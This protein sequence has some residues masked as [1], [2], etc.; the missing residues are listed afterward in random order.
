MTHLV[1]DIIEMSNSS[2]GTRVIQKVIE[3]VES[4]SLIE[5]ILKKFKEN[6]VGLVLDSNGNHVI[7]KCLSYFVPEQVDFM[8]MEI[9]AS[10]E[11][12]AT[13]KH[14][15]CVLQRCIDYCN[16]DQIKFVIGGILNHT[17]VLINDKFGNYVIQYILELQGYDEDKEEIGKSVAKKVDYYC[18]QKFSSNVIEKSIKID[19]T[20]VLD[21]LL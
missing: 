9:M 19:L 11:E 7:Q 2:H 14:G 12:V 4:Q 10:V 13:H 3:N 6:V 20:V 18:Y 1:P 8:Y 15:C 16:E 5:E 21:K 17:E